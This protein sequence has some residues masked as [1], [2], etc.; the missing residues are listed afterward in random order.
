[1][2]EP[3]SEVFNCDCMPYMLTLPDKFFELAIVDPPYGIGDRLC[4]GAGKHKNSR[5]RLQYKNGNRWDSIPDNNFF[6]ELF[7]IS[8][9]QIIWGGNYFALPPTRGIIA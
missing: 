9:N 4:N 8:K 5:M 3:I 7:R 2:P 1:M 6:V